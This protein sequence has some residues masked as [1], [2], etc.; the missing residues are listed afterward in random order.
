MTTLQNPLA[1]AGARTADPE[2][3]RRAP[4]Y[5]C[6]AG[7]RLAW[8]SSF[9]QYIMGECVDV[10]RTG[11]RILISQPIPDRTCVSFKSDALAL[12]GS[13]TV[14]FSRR[15]KGRYLV[16]LDF[17]GGLAWRP[18]QALDCPASRLPPLLSEAP[19]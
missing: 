19:T 10:S 5:R 8:T 9:D 2:R 13:G 14:R 4:R 3:R 12:A 17:A 11:L 1:T 15:H 18:S 6:S 7:I 16:G